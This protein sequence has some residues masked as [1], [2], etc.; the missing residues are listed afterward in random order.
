MLEAVDRKFRD[1]KDCQRCAYY[2]DC[3]EFWTFCP[4]D[5][6]IA[7]EKRNDVEIIED[8]EVF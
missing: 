4:Y 5:G 2:E 6:K 8:A 3:Y 7:V 1:V